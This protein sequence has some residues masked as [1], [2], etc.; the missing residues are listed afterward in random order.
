MDSL[1]CQTPENPHPISSAADTLP[2]TS[3]F[4]P[5]WPPGQLPGLDRLLCSSLVCHLALLSG[6]VFPARG[7]FRR[8]PPGLGSHPPRRLLS[9]AVVLLHLSASLSHSRDPESCSQTGEAGVLP[10]TEQCPPEHMCGSCNPHRQM[11]SPGVAPSAGIGGFLRRTHRRCSRCCVGTQCEGSHLHTRQG[12][13]P[14]TTS[15]HT[16]SS[17]CPPPELGAG[18]GCPVSPALVWFGF[19]CLFLCCIDWKS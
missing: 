6:S 3:A 13:R 7:G 4:S 11:K 15:P 9:F 18:N 12:A 14:Q 1:P 19:P 16:S 17:D 8:P 5:S 10:W 2:P